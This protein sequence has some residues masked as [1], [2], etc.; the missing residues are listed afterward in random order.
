MS[1][2]RPGSRGH[3]GHE[4]RKGYKVWQAELVTQAL[5]DRRVSRGRLAHVV[6]WAHK[7]RQVLKVFVV[8]GD[9][10]VCLGYAAFRAST[11]L[12]VR[13][14]Y[15]AYKAF[16]ASPVFKVQKGL[17]VLPVPVGQQVLKGQLAPKVILVLRAFREFKGFKVCR[18]SKGRLARRVRPALKAHKAQLV[19]RAAKE[20]RGQ[21]GLQESPMPVSSQAH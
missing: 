18:E 13:R 9:C 8:C 6:P 7:G 11:A 19:Q 10:R 1:I 3:K 12:P 16:K 17:K 14:A 20:L 2:L 4:D 15:R 5:G 21:P